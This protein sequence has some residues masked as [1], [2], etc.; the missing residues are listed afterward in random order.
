MADDRPLLA[1]VP[2]GGGPAPPLWRAHRL[3]HAALAELAGPPPAAAAIGY[4]RVEAE[5]SAPSIG[6]P[7]FWLRL[8]RGYPR[9]YFRDRS[10]GVCVAGVGECV[11]VHGAGPPDPADFAAWPPVD[12]WHERMRLVGGGR[13]DASAPADADWAA[14][15][16]HRFVLPAVEVQTHEGRTYLACHLRWDPASE[17]SW[18][19]ARCGALHAVHLSVPAAEPSSAHLP[20]LEG[21]EELTSAEAWRASVAHVLRA[22]DTGAVSKAVLARRTHCVLSD[23]V[24]PLEIAAR[25]L[26]AVETDDGGGDAAAGAETDDAMGAADGAPP[27]PLPPLPTQPRYGTLFCLQL[28]AGRGFVGCSPERLF[29]ADGARVQTEAVAGT[30]RRGGGAD[31]DAALGAELLASRKDLAENEAVQAFL[32]GALRPLCASLRAPRAARLLRLRHVQHL[33]V[34]FEGEL[35]PHHALGGDG[36]GGGGGEDGRRSVRGALA[37]LRVLHPTP[38]VCG[39]P[40]DAARGLIASLERS[41]RGWYAGPFGYVS[42]AR[43]D[44]CVA[45]RSALVAAPRALALFAGAGLV[46]GSDAAAE[47]A[48]CADKMTNFRALFA[49][50]LRY[51]R[52]PSPTALHGC[53]A[54]EELLRCGVRHFALCPGSRSTP[55]TAA[56]AAHAGVSTVV[57]H[58]ERTAGFYAV[59]YARAARRAAAIVVTSG[60]AVANLLPAVVEAAAERLPL[61]VLS[62]DRPWELRDTGANQTIDQVRGLG[63]RR[64]RGWLF[65]EV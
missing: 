36:G 61:L 29:V 1:L 9:V 37:L 51:E 23:E 17:A 57:F 26:D 52:L 44:F 59:G 48:E 32:R 38:A 15:G 30:R 64:G 16:G 54:I 14:Y 46:A 35:A 19:R 56:A 65:G 8:Q 45:I 10:R 55:L 25:F 20:S 49:P 6:E 58:D 18:E 7:L 4:L 12:A 40:C 47:Y 21:L 53:A 50:A 13:F 3:L 43:A 60:T 2:D 42:R 34:P 22:I 28:S 27:S 63:G 5:V 39:T 11:S 33:Y 41:D 62:A 24:E 31:A